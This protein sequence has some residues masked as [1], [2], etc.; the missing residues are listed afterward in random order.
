[1]KKSFLLSLSVVL[2]VAIVACGGGNK[3]GGEDK[4]AANGT[5]KSESN[6][7]KDDKLSGFMLGGIYF[8][9]GYGGQAAVSKMITSDDKE[10]IVAAYKKMFELPF[11]PGD[12]DAGIKGNLKSMW[13]ISDKATM[14]KTLEEL[15]SGKA[16]NKHRA[17]DYARLVNN[18]CMG[19][20]AGY[21]TDA[22]AEKYVAEVLPLAKKD[23]KTW[24]DYFTDFNAGRK[25]WGGDPSGDKHFEDA[26]KALLSDNKS[27]YK[28]LPLN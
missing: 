28:A 24:E 9:D 13:D 6:E 4:Q 14:I 11:K 1:M 21:L 12:D 23:F 16:D 27:I 22:E 5:E 26:A 19:Y 18:A 7:V 3:K 10:A 8:V 2:C 20:A 25:A 15:K 17:W